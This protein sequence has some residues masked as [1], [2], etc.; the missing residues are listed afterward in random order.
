[1]SLQEPSK[2][3]SKSDE[4]L[5]NLIS[6]LDTPEIITKKIKRAVTDSG[7]TINYDQGR[8]GLANLIS[9]YSLIS[10]LSYQEIENKYEG[11]MYSDFKKD[12]AEMIIE[13][14]APIQSKYSEIINDKL[15]LEQVLSQGAEKSYYRARKTISK[16]YRK[17]GFIP[18]KP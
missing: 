13:Y 5:N 15:Y 10:D 14:L 11:K 4:N 3:M 8:P 1:M 9:I 6:L 16:V 12:L 2:K 18:K 7:S 17:V